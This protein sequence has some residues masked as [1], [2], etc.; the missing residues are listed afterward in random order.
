MFAWICITDGEYQKYL[1]EGAESLDEFM[2]WTYTFNEDDIAKANI[3]GNIH[4]NPELL[5]HS[6]T[7]SR[8][9]PFKIKKNMTWTYK[10]KNMY[11]F[12][13]WSGSYT[14]T[15]YYPNDFV[16]FAMLQH[17]LIFDLPVQVEH[18]TVRMFYN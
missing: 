5:R 14:F 16:E 13:Q 2:F 7:T 1:D 8:T 3:C 12:D 4:Q 11:R 17:E 18:H 10:L 6:Q 9:T 15:A